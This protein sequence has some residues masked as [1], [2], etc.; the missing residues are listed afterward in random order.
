MDLEEAVYVKTT[1]DSGLSPLVSDRVY[2]VDMPS[3]AIFPLIL[4]TIVSN[5]DNITHDESD[6]ETLA[7]TRVQFEVWSPSFKSIREVSK[8][9]FD[10]WQGFKGAITSGAGSLTVQG[11]WRVSK[12][13]GREGLVDLYW[14]RQ[15]FIIK[16]LE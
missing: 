15:D 16:Y 10:C 6:Q 14:R 2:P 5:E 11:S 12:M 8:A 1:T 9:L 3:E 7:T 13:T 4:Y